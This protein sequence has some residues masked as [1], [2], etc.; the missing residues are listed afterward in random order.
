MRNT[1][2]ARLH[3]AIC[4]SFMSLIF[5]LPLLA[6][7]P[8]TVSQTHPGGSSSAVVPHLVKFSGTVKDADGKPRSGLVGITFAL[9]KEEQGGAPLWLETQSVQADSLGHYTV[10]LGASKPDGLPQDVFLS[11]EARWLGVQ[12]EGQ[13]EPPRTL[14]LSVPYALKA[15]DAATIGGLPPSAFVLAYPGNGSSSSPNNSSANGSNQPNVGGSGTQNY[16]PIWTDN[17]GDLGNS[18]LFQFGTGNS[19]ELGIN[20]TTPAATLNVNG[21]A[22]ARGPLQLPAT[23]TANANQ[24]YNSQPFDLQGSAYTGSKVIGPLFQLQTEPSGNNTSGAAGTLN[25]LYSNGSGQPTETGLNIASNGLISFVKTQTFPNTLTGITAGTG[26]NVTGSKTNP[27]VGINVTFANQNFANLNNANTFSKSQT[28]NGTM[29]ATNFSGNG[30]GL[31][32]VNAAQLGGLSSSAFAQLAQ[33]NTFT[34]N[35]TVNGNMAATQ[36]ISTVA[37]G[38]APLQVNSSTQVPNLNASYLGG[39]GAGAFQPAGSYASLG[40]NSFNGNQS[41]TGNVTATGIVSAGSYQIGIFP[42]AFG[43]ISNGNAFLGF[44]GNTTTTGTG[45]VANGP[46]ALS[47]DTSGGGNTANGYQALGGNGSGGENTATGEFALENNTTGFTNTASGGQALERNTTGSNNTADGVLALG[48]ATTGNSDTATGAEALAANTTGSYN[49]A[50]GV[51]ALLNNTTGFNNTAV[52]Y[53]AGPDAGHPGLSN[54]TA[55]GENAVVSESNALVLGGT[56]SDAV[57]VGIGT[58]TPGATLDVHGTGNFTGP[59]TF[60]AGQVFP[61]TGTVTSVGSGAGLT[62]GPITGTGSLS[63][64]TG[65]VSNAMLA[66]S[67]LTVAAGTDLTGGGPVSLGG[68]TTLALDTTKVPQLNASNT[69][70]GNQSIN[71]SVVLT[72]GIDSG[73]NISAGGNIS[74]SGNITSSGNII[75]NFTVTGI[76]VN[77]GMYMLNGQPFG[78]G[79]STLGNAFLGFAGN[80]SMTGEGNTATGQL[81]LSQ[82][83]S[84]NGNTADGW[85][86]LYYNTQGFDNTAEGL[87]ALFYNTTG[88]QNTAS[89]YGTLSSN[90][91]G[92]NNAAFGLGAL[93]SLQ[94]SDGNTAVGTFALFY[95]TGGSLNTAVGYL[96]GPGANQTS[97]NNSAAIGA[98]AEVDASNAMVLGSINGVNNATASTNVGIGTTTPLF[99]FHVA[100]AGDVPANGYFRVE[101][102]AKSGTNIALASFG[103]LG[104]FKIDGPGIPAGRF[105]VKENGQVT[106]QTPTPQ[107]GFSLTIKNGAGPAISDTW[108]TWSSRRFKTNI[109]TLPDAL[110]KVERLRGVSYDRKDSGKHEIGV[111]AE[112]VGAVVPE[113]VS[114]ESNG[115]DARG[116]DY[117]RLTA[118]LIEAVKQQQR[119]I[120]EQRNQIRVQQGQIA[121]L[122][123]KVGVLEAALHSGG[124]TRT[125]TIKTTLSAQVATSGLTRP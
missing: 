116:V 109:Q 123:G 44:S 17:S 70:N 83:T 49:T 20:T 55:I 122:N 68:T 52:G 16:I 118:L 2:N 100:S 65:G 71:G 66:N 14:L 103:G 86:A 23:G 84:G 110:H 124:R 33:P 26:I 28:V 101:G 12:P 79:N 74:S 47:A 19:A 92:N 87:Q 94:G 4:V 67:S 104:D 96:A 53:N 120:S 63:I 45:N 6:Q 56:G 24:G 25:L 41:V 93:Y 102:P 89:G 10:Y 76:Q 73:T 60:A 22:I 95:P 43:N 108:A 40:S 13:A 62:G 90:Q 32:N 91:T 51:N 121:R 58:A 37:Q 46:F 8:P 39:L 38:T 30:S 105:A 98:N 64:A 88:T 75:A 77:S 7:A 3:T 97:L 61:G 59:I 115:K 15:G 113:V 11:G 9:Y 29:T 50:S 34:A 42:F 117:S 27:T 111:I 85:Q 80:T 54:S 36:M 72:G 18:G 114:W 78:L 69:F 35:Q 82:A 125:H 48:I 99:R 5:S 107:P 119:E 21:G 81:A 57:S 1:R 112:E 106:I 31:T